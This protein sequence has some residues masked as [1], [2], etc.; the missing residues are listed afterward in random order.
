MDILKQFLTDTA[1]AIR[2]KKGTTAKIYPEDMPSEILTIEGNGIIPTGTLTITSNGTHNVKNYE[3]AFV[4]VASGETPSDPNLIPENI[5]KGVTIFGVTGTYEGEAAASV[6][7]VGSDLSGKTLTLEG[8]TAGSD[9]IGLYNSLYPDCGTYQEIEVSFE[10][11][12]NLIIH[13]NAGGS[14]DSM[15][16]VTAEGETLFGGIMGAGLGILSHDF[17]DG[18]VITSI[19]FSDQGYTVTDSATIE[20]VIEWMD[21]HLIIE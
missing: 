2:S 9:E 14:P 7:S 21:S 5:K 6:W 16:S 17:S 10:N 11:G 13:E 4:N 15:S 8:F 1:N 19:R 18:S 20:K 12:K 3:S